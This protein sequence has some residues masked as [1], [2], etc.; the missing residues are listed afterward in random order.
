MMTDISK[1]LNKARELEKNM[2]ESQKKIK[3]IQ[4][5]GVSGGDKVKITLNGDG[6]IIKIY[7]SNEIL[8]EKID[9]VYDLII[10]AHNNA[11]ESIKQKTSEEISKVSSDLGIPGLKWPL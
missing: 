10:A 2:K 9:I 5:T 6:D 4:A 8:N 7:I 11:K 3:E 1:L